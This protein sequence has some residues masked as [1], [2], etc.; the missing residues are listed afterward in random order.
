MEDYSNY[1]TQ[2]VN[3]DVLLLINSGIKYYQQQDLKN[4]LASFNQAINLMPE[5]ANL[6]TFRGNVYQDLENNSLAEKDFRKTIELRPNDSHANF[7]LG[8]MYSQKNDF[9]NAVKFL[10]ISY[11]NS[12]GAN[13][14]LIGFGTNNLLVVSRQ[15]ICNNLGNFLGQLKRYDEAIKYLKEAIEIEPHYANPHIALGILL[16][17]IGKVNEGITYIEK[18]DKLGVPQAKLIL[19]MLNKQ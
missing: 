14:D 11:R 8:I 17:Q 10:E 15:V 3:P 2:K 1:F 12:L 5:N 13:L 18:A 16:L 4:S 19:Q 6:Y 9:E 7:R